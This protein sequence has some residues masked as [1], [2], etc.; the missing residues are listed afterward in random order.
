M[1]APTFP[2]GERQEG[3]TGYTGSFVFGAFM[4]I[5]RVLRQQ[6]YQKLGKEMTFPLFIKLWYLATAI[7]CTWTRNKV[8][9]KNRSKKR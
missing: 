7:P 4:V 2:N 6:F 3:D 8:K 5:I 9:L 1:Q